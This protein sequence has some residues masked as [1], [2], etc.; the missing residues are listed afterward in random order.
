M[1]EDWIEYDIISQWY[2]IYNIDKLHMVPVL[3]DWP[4]DAIALEWKSIKTSLYIKTLAVVIDFICK[5]IV[6]LFFSSHSGS[7]Y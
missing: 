1:S 3:K 4:R 5:I 2:V 7:K 6:S